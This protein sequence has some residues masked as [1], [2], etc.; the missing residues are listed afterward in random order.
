M[1]SLAALLL[2]TLTAG[3]AAA[4]ARPAKE[5]ALPN[6]EKVRTGVLQDPAKVDSAHYTVEYEDAAIR[7]L[8]VRLGPG[9]SSVMHEHPKAMCIVALT[10]E[11]TTHTLPDGTKTET[12]HPAGDVD[13]N[14]TEA[15]WYRHNPSNTGDAVEEFIVIERKAA[16]YGR[17]LQPARPKSQGPTRKTP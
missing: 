8:R 14:K 2:V 1:R 7:I 10:A 11:H 9:E 3:T 6:R 13:C 17:G 5:E 15:G 4:Q 12:T 16:A